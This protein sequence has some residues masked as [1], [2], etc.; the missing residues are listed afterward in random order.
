MAGIGALTEDVEGS[1]GWIF[2][3]TL[4]M[5]IPL[6]LWTAIANAPNGLLALILSLFPYSAPVAMLMR[7]T[8]SA[9]PPWQL[10]MSLGLLLV[11]V[12]GTIWLM[13]RLFRAQTLLSGEPLSLSRFWT[14][15]RS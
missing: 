10:T 15:L 12:V 13:A 11:A 4:P 14:A 6:Y 3:L 8:A 5:M 2:V 9:V 1:R 7:M